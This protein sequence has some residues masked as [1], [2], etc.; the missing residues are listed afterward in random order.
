M[1]HLKDGS[2]HDPTRAKALF[3]F[4]DLLLELV[5]ALGPLERHD[6]RRVNARGA[7]RFDEKRCRI[8]LQNQLQPAWRF[9]AQQGDDGA[10]SRQSPL[11]GRGE[12]QEFIV[13]QRHVW[14]TFE[15]TAR[16]PTRLP[17]EDVDTQ[18]FAIA[19]SNPSIV[20]FGSDGGIWRTTNVNAATIV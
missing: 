4:D 20:Y 19:P 8:E 7:Q 14:L 1:H 12:R 6:Q 5:G 11:R 16:L 13:D 17:R 10:S 15:G 3:Q 9:R 18:A 2:E